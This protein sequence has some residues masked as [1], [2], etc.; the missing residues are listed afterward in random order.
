M[1]RLVFQGLRDNERTYENRRVV[2]RG[3]II[4]PEY[5]YSGPVGFVV[6]CSNLGYLRVASGA[7]EW[8]S[9]RDQGGRGSVLNSPSYIV[10]LRDQLIHDM[11]S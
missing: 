7:V 9:R 8:R 11:G 6:C 2:S 4:N 3:E 1:S 10:S 5:L